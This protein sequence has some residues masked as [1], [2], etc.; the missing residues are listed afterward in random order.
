MLAQLSGPGVRGLIEQHVGDYPIARPAAAAA[1]TPTATPAVD[2]LKVLEVFPADGTTLAVGQG[3]TVGAVVEVVSVSRENRRVVLSY[4]TD[5]GASEPFA[6]AIV[7]GGVGVVKLEGS[8]VVPDSRL[9]RIVAQLG[10]TSEQ[11]AF[12]L[13]A[14]APVAVPVTA[15]SVLRINSNPFNTLHPQDPSRV[16]AAHTIIVELFSGLVALNSDQEV[17]PD[18]ATG[19]EIQKGVVYTF[20]LNQDARF[21][22]GDPVWAQDFKW[23]MERA[24]K[25]VWRSRRFATSYLGDI[26]GAEQFIVGTTGGIRGIQVIDD[27]TLRIIIDA[28]KPYFL[29]KLA[30][31]L[32]FVLHRG[33]VEERRARMVGRKPGGNRAL[34]AW[35]V[36]PRRAHSPEE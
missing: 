18:I 30:D 11:A 7:E 14:H 26:L 9:I 25:S 10:T 31:P 16:N 15:E 5:S 21:H 32:A 36:R 4:E 6:E 27:L 35:G 8:F 20:K 3:V 2:S 29:T 22:N 34:H 23:S 19:W 33:S 28:P 13:I 1:P 24:A 17:V 12:Y